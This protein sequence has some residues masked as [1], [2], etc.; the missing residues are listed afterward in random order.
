MGAAYTLA[1]LLKVPF[2]KEKQKYLNQTAAELEKPKPSSQGK[3]MPFPIS[4]YVLKPD[5]MDKLGYPLPEKKDGAMQLPEGFVSTLPEGPSK[6][7]KYYTHFLWKDLVTDM[8]S[9]SLSAL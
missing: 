2:S 4:Y 8:L 5:M 3:E 7:N 9:R 6:G 1:M